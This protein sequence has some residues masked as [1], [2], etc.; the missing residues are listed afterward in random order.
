MSLPISYMNFE[1]LIRKAQEIILGVNVNTA[2]G[3]DLC[4]C[5]QLN[6][7]LGRNIDV[8]SN[9]CKETGFISKNSKNKVP[10]NRRLLGFVE[11]FAYH[12]R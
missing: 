9:A 6:R 11:K 5:C 12:Y 1:M 3:V 4:R 2:I 10:G 8:L 7:A